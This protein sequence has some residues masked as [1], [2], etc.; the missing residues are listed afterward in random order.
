MKRL[1]LWASVVLLPACCVMAKTST[2]NPASHDTLVEQLEQETPAIVRWYDEDKTDD[3]DHPIH[4]DDPEKIPDD[5]KTTLRAFCSAV[6]LTNDVMLTAA[7]CV[8]DI[9]KPASSDDDD[10]IT[11]PVGKLQHL[12]EMLQHGQNPMTETARWSPVGQTVYYSSHGDVDVKHKAYH[13]GKVKAVDWN[14]D[15]ALIKAD[16]PGNHPV[17]RLRVSDVHD[18]EELHIIGHPLGMWWTYVHGYVAAQRPEYHDDHGHV[19]PITQVS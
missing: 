19:Y 7:H 10:D 13:S 3:D 11:D 12:L 14:N 4:Y 6:W 2:T 9:G 1:A 15:I 5:A 8:D 18:G 17:A 16:S